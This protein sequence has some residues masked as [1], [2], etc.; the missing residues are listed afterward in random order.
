MGE[1]ELVGTG[2]Y[3]LM[4]TDGKNMVRISLLASIPF[5][6]MPDGTAEITIKENTYVIPREVKI[7]RYKRWPGSATRE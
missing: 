5:K 2:R 1:N 6:R 7:R 3:L 4:T